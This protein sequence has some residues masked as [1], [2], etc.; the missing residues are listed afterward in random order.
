[1]SK[2]YDQSYFDRWYR[3]P[4]HRV[5]TPAGVR[6][7]VRLT[8]GIAEA[9]LERPVRSVLDVGCGEAPWRSHFLDE[10][11]KVEYLGVDSSEYVVERFGRSRGIRAGTFGTLGQI[12]ITT[13]FDL[14]VCCDVLQYVRTEELRPGLA[15]VSGLLD[16]VAY[17]EAFTDADELEGDKRHWHHR[18]PAFYRQAFRAAG[19]SAVGMHCY[20]GAQLVGSTLALERAE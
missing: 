10:R 19:L 11:P 18:T 13:K 20:V 8:L 9:L 3:D 15:A 5:N 6:R 2:R 14:I 1:V 17:L 7:K 4:R 12:G 16:G